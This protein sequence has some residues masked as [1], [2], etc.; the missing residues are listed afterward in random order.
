VERQDIGQHSWISFPKHRM[1]G[2]PIPLHRNFEEVNL[3]FYVRRKAGDDWRRAVVF[4]K[5]LVPRHSI[6]FVARVLYNEKYA[7]VPMA[8]NV[9]LPSET[10]GATRCCTL[11]GMRAVKNTIKLVASGPPQQITPGSL[12]EFIT[13]HY[14]GYS[15]MRNGSTLEYRVDHPQWRI[16]EADSSHLVC[17]VE[18]L[19]GTPF[20]EVLSQAPSSAF[21]AEGSGV[22]VFKGVH[23]VA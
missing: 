19:Y 18:S 12:Q 11:G 6:A 8:H 2:I 9:N 22:K 23:L 4:I 3:R 17:N 14:W 15:T 21:L 1:F 16:W 7:W 10:N 13:E 20:V 5:E